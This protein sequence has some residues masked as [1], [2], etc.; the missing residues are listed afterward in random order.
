MDGVEEEEE[1]GDKFH[2]FPNDEG[3]GFTG[4]L[5]QAMEGNQMA[6]G[7]QDQLCN[8][9]SVDMQHISSTSSFFN[10]AGKRVIEHENHIDDNKR[11][12]IAESW[13]PK[14]VD[15]G[16]CMEKIQQMAERARFFYVEKE[17]ALEQSNMNQQI[18]LNELQK[19]DNVI[20]HLH[21]TRVEEIQKKDS[22]IYRLERELYLMGNVLDG[23]RK[24]IK[25]TQK[26]FAEYRERAQLPEETT[27][28]DAGPGGLML[29][30]A[31]IERLRKKEEE[32]FK[33]N[34]LIIEHKMKEA[35][36]DYVSQFGGYLEKVDLL[37]KKLTGLEANAKELIELYAK[38]KTPQAEENVPEVAEPE[39][40]LEAE[41]KVPEVEE[42]VPIPETIEKVP[43][44]AEPLTQPA[45]EAEEKAPEVEEPVPIPETIEKVPEVAEPLPE[46]AL[47]AE[48]KAPEVEEPVP[49]PDT[50]EKVPEVAEPLPS[51]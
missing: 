28:R 49:I 46:P 36:N 15:F 35:E 42:P 30:V 37:D 12:R 7:S 11:L 39:S 34:C 38:L 45:L 21:K 1:E 14:P 44:V 16:T 51:E 31:E 48:E 6:F 29:S 27:Y 20:E 18:L 3:D 47:E 8:P 33:M 5:L 9:S 24:A 10:S 50:I 19:R 17:Q 40:A 26:A 2:V 13:D 4:N 41:E 22:Q 43:E 32:E 23:Y 25:E